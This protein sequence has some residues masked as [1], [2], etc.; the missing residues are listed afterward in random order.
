MDQKPCVAEEIEPKLDPLPVCCGG[1]MRLGNGRDRSRRLG[2]DGRAVHVNVGLLLA[3]GAGLLAAV[4]RDVSGLAALVAGLAGRVERAAVG[5]GAVARDVSELA[6]GVAL[7]GLRL[8]VTSKVVGAAALVA[9]R[10]ASAA[11]KASPCLGEAAAAGGGCPVEAGN[12]GNR[13]VRAVAS[14]VANRVAVVAPVAGARAAAQT[15]GRALSLDVA[16]TLAV[17]ALLRLG[18][19]GHG[20]LVRLMVG[21]LA[22]V[23][24]A[25]RRDT[26][27]GLVAELTALV[28]RAT[29]GRH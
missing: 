7:H 3:V 10:L 1:E 21:L 22:V 6:T 19:A 13:G 12:R 8:A 5:G 11:D 9:G 24:E 15:Q 23:A 14:Q 27:V 25:V 28:A 29:G 18:R 2:R 17:V 20:A 26:L 4:T 16:E